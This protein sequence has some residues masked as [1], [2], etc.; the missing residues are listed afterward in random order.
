MYATTRISEDE[1]E[2]PRRYV[3]YKF[4]FNIAAFDGEGGSAA[5]AGSAASGEASSPAAGESRAQGVSSETVAAA[6]EGSISFDQ[7]VKDHQ[8]EATKWFNKQFNRRHADYKALSERVAAT[9]PIMDMLAMKFGIEDAGDVK[10]ITEALEQD[11]YLYAERAEANNRTIDEQREWDRIDRENRMFREQQQAM[12]RKEQAN[13]Q[14]E[15][16]M[17]QSGNLKQLFPS[18]DLD[19]ELANPEFRDALRKGLSM[20]RAFY[21]IHGEEITTGAMQYTAQAVRQATVEDMSQRRNRPQE[22]GLSRQAAAKVSKDVHSLTKADRARIAA[23]S[24]RGT[25]RF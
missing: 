10:A 18:F 13:K 14:Y 12:Q 4:M 5:A 22:N 9:S 21:A 20:E 15:E 23:E 16:W 6:Q 25:Y 8:D 19:K 2:R 7:Y 24:M 11:D 1:R 17:Q 3:M